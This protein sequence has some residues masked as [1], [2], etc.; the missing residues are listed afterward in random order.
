VRGVAIRPGDLILADDTGVVVVPCDFIDKV[1]AEA[2]SAEEKE[3]EL[4]EAINRGW[5]VRN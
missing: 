4:V 2:E 1:L 3:K 5:R